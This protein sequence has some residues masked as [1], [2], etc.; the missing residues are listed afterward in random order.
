[1]R[2]YEDALAYSAKWLDIVNQDSSSLDEETAKWMSQETKHNFVNHFNAGWVNYRKSMTEA[3]DYGATEWRGEG[4][5]F[6]DNFGNEYL[7][8]L[9]GYGALDLGW[10]HPEVVA[11]VRHPQPGTDGPFVRG[12]GQADGRH[13]S[14]RHR[15]RLFV[16]S[17][18][19]TVANILIASHRS[20]PSLNTVSDRHSTLRGHQFGLGKIALL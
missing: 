2:S 20:Q 10:S 8:F 14:R 17:G 15:P 13:D 11:A 16:A 3:G 5:R 4:A 9:G 1:M 18:T 6:Y 12:P 19:E 7:D